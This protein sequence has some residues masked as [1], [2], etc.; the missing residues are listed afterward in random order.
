MSAREIADHITLSTTGVRSHIS[1]IYERCGI[2]AA[3]GQ[4]MRLLL[5][6]LAEGWLAEI[7][8]PRYT[9]EYSTASQYRKALWIPSPAERLYLDALDELLRTRD[10]AAERD[11][12]L[13][14]GL[15][16]H[17][18]RVAKVPGRGRDVDAM[19]RLLGSV[20]CT[21]EQRLLLR[22]F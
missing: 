6:M 14:H 8:I 12:L 21:P 10:R 13:Y 2:I 9:G 1:K 3:G 15:M 17:V 5:M 11:T 4:N 18:R 19:F 16:R 20:I 7:E 22:Y